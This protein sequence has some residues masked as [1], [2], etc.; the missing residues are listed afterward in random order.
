MGQ[1][2]NLYRLSEL[3]L[4]RR[5]TRRSTTWG[6]G[7]LFFDASTRAV[8][9][10][11]FFLLALAELPGDVGTSSSVAVGCSGR[12]ATARDFLFQLEEHGQ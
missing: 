10:R 11:S 12:I 8:S 4:D 6:L 9:F 3:A 7:N 5:L 1:T 2:N